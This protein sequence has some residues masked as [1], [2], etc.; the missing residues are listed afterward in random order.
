MFIAEFD[1]PAA[2]QAGM[3]SPEGKAAVA[4][5]PNYSPKGVTVVD[6]QPE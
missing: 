5:I 1:S 4:D 3:G 2:M 6:M